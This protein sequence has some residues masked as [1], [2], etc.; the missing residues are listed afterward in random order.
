MKQTTPTSS[1]PSGG[2]TKNE[3]IRQFSMY[4]QDNRGQ[5]VD[6]SSS[7]DVHRSSSSFASGSPWSRWIFNRSS[8]GDNRR[9]SISDVVPNT[10]KLYSVLSNCSSPTES[11]KSR[12]S[13]DVSSFSFRGAC[14]IAQVLTTNQKR[15]DRQEVYKLLETR[16]GMGAGFLVMFLILHRVIGV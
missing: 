8:A 14:L 4:G 12:P 10:E 11:E 9:L 3:A 15:L 2:G 7:S 6:S 5:N 16:K 13:I 1:D